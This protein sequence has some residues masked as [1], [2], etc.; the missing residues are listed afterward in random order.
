MKNNL[1]KT[2]NPEPS[3]YKTQIRIH[4]FS[5]LHTSVWYSGQRLLV[6]GSIGYPQSPVSP[7]STKFNS[8]FTLFAEHALPTFSNHSLDESIEITQDLT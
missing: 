8:G 4:A 5:M 1:C 6:L 7:T 2:R 3:I